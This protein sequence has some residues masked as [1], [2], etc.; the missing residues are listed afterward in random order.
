MLLREVL[1]L[2]REDRPGR[3]GWSRRPVHPVSQLVQHTQEGV[4]V[5]VPDEWL[6]LLL[7]LGLQ[8]LVPVGLLLVLL[9]RPASARRLLRVP[10]T[11]STCDF[12][13]VRPLLPVL[14]FKFLG[15]F[16][17]AFVNENLPLRRHFATSLAGYRQKRKKWNR[18]ELALCRIQTQSTE[19]R[20]SPSDHTTNLD[21][22]LL[23]PERYKRIHG[24]RVEYVLCQN[25]TKHKNL[26]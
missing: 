23:L 4:L 7:V 19:C 8:M 26:L 3:G 1:I 17:S 6:V 2:I 14:C 22:A 5:G 24:Y 10:M 9:L 18:M 11:W 15:C 12:G 13:I 25:D 20:N 21:R 16:V